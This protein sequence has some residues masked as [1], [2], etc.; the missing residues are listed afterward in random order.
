MTLSSETK[1]IKI[2]AMPA[3]TAQHF[4]IKA[5]LRPIGAAFKLSEKKLNQPQ[6]NDSQNSD[7]K[8]H[9]MHE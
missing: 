2:I 4:Q 5:G 7:S 1:P 6:I 3:Q 8:P 9:I